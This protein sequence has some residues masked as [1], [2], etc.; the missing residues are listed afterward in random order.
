[1][2]LKELAQHNF[3]DTLNKMKESFYSIAT[4][5]STD[6]NDAKLY[7]L[8]VKTFDDKEGKVVCELLDINE[9]KESS[10]GVNIFALINE[11]FEKRD[12]SGQRCISFGAD[13]AAVLHGANAGVAAFVKEFNP[14]VYFI[15]CPCHL[16]HIAAQKGTKALKCQLDDLIVDIF[17]HIEKAVKEIKELRNVRR[18]LV[19]HSK[20]S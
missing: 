6:I 19:Y 9:C 2:L 18:S 14:S 8:V 3:H 15:G 16:M 17:Y 10:S 11:E 4:D 7:P 13:N 20:K 1:M 5:G 12:M